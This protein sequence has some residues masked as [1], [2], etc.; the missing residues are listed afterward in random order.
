MTLASQREIPR[1]RRVVCARCGTDFSCGLSG[2]CWCASVPV[3]L[4]LPGDSTEDCLCPSC[5]RK[6]GE[7]VLHSSDHEETTR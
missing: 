1:G 6:A 4:P 3:R 2:E 7:A 5:L